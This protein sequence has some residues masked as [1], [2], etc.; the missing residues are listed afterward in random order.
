MKKS[1]LPLIVALFLLPSFVLAAEERG[2]KIYYDD[3]R[4][5]PY[6]P[7]KIG[8]KPGRF[9]VALPEQGKI[10]VVDPQSRS[11]V[12]LIPVPAGPERLSAVP[13]MRYLYVTHQEGDRLTV[14]DTKDAQ[15]LRGIEEGGPP[16]L[17]LIDMSD[18]VIRE[19]KIGKGRP[20]PIAFS[21]VDDLALVGNADSEQGEVAYIDTARHE[22]VGA[23]RTRGKKTG[24]VVF[25]HDG[26]YA[27]LGNRIGPL[28]LLDVKQGTVVKSLPVEDAVAL[29]MS[30]DGQWLLADSAQGYLAVISVADG[31]VSRIEIGPERA[32][33]LFS[34]DGRTAYIGGGKNLAMIDLEKRA[35]KGRIAAGP[36]PLLSS[37]LPDR[38]VAVI[39]SGLRPQQISLIDL[40]EERVIKK[41][42]AGRSA[43]Q[44]QF[45]A[46]ARYGLISNSDDPFVTL[47]DGKR[48]D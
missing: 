42:Q 27:F 15:I 20:A 2:T 38:N 14:I 35:V 24:E 16:Q 19:L 26:A 21:P 46:D 11:V 40:G 8:A 18:Q 34:R 22:V 3:L 44:V 7:E 45:S 29:R 43:H 23:V 1:V 9:Y 5:W 10:A 48:L 33:L 28:D 25:T 36:H 12:K 6:E 31:S 30:P 39:T 17:A 47:I 37:L 13:G 41:I 4:N 32:D